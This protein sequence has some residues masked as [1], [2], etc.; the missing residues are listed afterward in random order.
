MKEDLQGRQIIAQYAMRN[1]IVTAS[2]TLTNGTNTTLI[3]GDSDYPLDIIEVSFSND[4][5]V[6]A[7]VVLKDDGT[8][9][10]TINIPASGTVELNPIIPFKQN[11]KGGNWSGDMIDVTGT[12]VTIEATLIK[13]T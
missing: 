10:K 12:N 13:N 9:V 5:T 7:Q 6:A 4:S 3:S 2:V 1:A 8:T 11:A